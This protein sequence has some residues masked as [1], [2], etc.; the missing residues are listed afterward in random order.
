MPRFV[1]IDTEATGL[2]HSRHELTEVAWIVRFEDGSEVT[3]QYFPSH[4]LDGAEPA[5]LRLTNYDEAIAPRE[6]TPARVWLRR[7]LADANGAHLVGAVPDFDAHHLTLMCR[8][9]GWEVTW[10]HHLIDV[11]TLALPLIADTPA[12]PRSLARTARALGLAHDDDKAHG[13]LYDAQQAMA[14]FDAV[15]QRLADLRETDAPLPPPVRDQRS[16][17]QGPTI[18]FVAVDDDNR[19]SVAAVAPRPQQRVWAPPSVAHLLATTT[20]TDDDESLALLNEGTVAGHAL[21]HHD[22]EVAWIT[23]F[24]VDARHQGRGAAVAAARALLDRLGDGERR[25]VIHPDNCPGHRLADTVGFVPTTE[26]TS[27]GVVWVRPAANRELPDVGDPHAEI[28]PGD[29]DAS[30]RGTDAA[31]RT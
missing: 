9:L 25:V 21:V 20:L 16:R 31:D 10:D 13:A 17:K 4:T 26:V 12:G 22:G 28:A 18:A 27:S 5:A 2:D 30:E 11:G 8:K 29:G 23:S 7:F 19:E 15:W 6:Q 14:V 1:F 24:V 3:R